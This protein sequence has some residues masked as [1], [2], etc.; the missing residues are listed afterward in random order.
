LHILEQNPEKID[1]YFL[2]QNPSALHLLEQN[3]EK[4]NW[5]ELS[6]N[7]SAL[8]LLEKNQENQWILFDLERNYSIHA[9]KDQEDIELF[10]SFQLLRSK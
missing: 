1:W 9:N 3:P 2:S 6:L 8:H 4:I 7:P 10:K 5:C